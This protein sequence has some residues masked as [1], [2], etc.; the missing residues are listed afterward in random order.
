MKQ[1][2]AP[3]AANALSPT[4]SLL[5]GTSARCGVSSSRRSCHRLNVACLS[6][7]MSQAG[8]SPTRSASTARCAASVVLPLPPFCEVITIVFK[9]A[10]FH[11]Y[12]LSGKVAGQA[13]GNCGRC[14]HGR[15]TKQHRHGRQTSVAPLTMHHTRHDL[16]HPLKPRSPKGYV[17]FTLTVVRAWTIDSSDARL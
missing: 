13:S 4:S 12:M 6:V 2:A 5:K 8:A 9:K 7:S 14:R 1:Y 11:E 17:L 10:T 16:V 3:R 15:D